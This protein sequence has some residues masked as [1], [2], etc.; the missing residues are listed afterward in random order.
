MLRK[1]INGFWADL[2]MI[3]L[4]AVWGMWRFQRFGIPTE[5]PLNTSLILRR[6]EFVRLNSLLSPSGGTRIGIRVSST[7]VTR[8]HC[9]SPSFC[10][11][12]RPWDWAD[13]VMWPFGG[14]DVR[15]RIYSDIFSCFSPKKHTFLA[16]QN[17]FPLPFGGNDI[18]STF[19]SSWGSLFMCQRTRRVGKKYCAFRHVWIVHWF[20][21]NN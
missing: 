10:K 15:R 4:A 19:P 7:R 3:L 16:C 11:W 6:S 21:V 12:R 9:A 14:G 8:N 1:K 5:D 13:L 20:V 17:V 18:G 2:R